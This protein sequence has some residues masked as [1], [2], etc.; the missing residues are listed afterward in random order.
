MPK[1]SKKNVNRKEKAKLF[2]NKSRFLLLPI[3]SLLYGYSL[4]SIAG[5]IAII[6][7]CLIRRDFSVFEEI[8]LKTLLIIAIGIFI[9]FPI[10]KFRK[11]MFDNL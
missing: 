1:P 11:G 4:I 7:I 6:A 3:A 9:F 2:N 5:L 8:S 10:R